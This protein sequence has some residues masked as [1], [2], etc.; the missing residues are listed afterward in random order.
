MAITHASGACY[1]GSNPGG[2]TKLSLVKPSLAGRPTFC[3][4][5]Y[6][7][8]LPDSPLNIL[9]RAGYSFLRKD[10]Q[11]GEMSFG[12]RVS[13][14]EYPRFH[15]FVK[16]EGKGYVFNIHIDQKKA[17]YQ[18]SNAHSGEYEEENKWLQYE[19]GQ[20]KKEIERSLSS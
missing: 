8:N 2:P 11:T 14:G 7:E 17:S 15:L 16:K 10:E 5:L 19:A 1:P 9:R 3:M 12:K 6:F 4:R 18:G 13:G 20:I